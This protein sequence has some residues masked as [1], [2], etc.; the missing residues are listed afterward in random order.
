MSE[1]ISKKVIN[2]FSKHNSSKNEK[3]VKSFAG[4]SYVRMDNDI[5]GYPFKEE[6]LLKYA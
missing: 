4:Y 5:N 1:E 6:K 3:V 2:I